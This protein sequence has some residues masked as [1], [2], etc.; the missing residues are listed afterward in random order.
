MICLVVVVFG[1]LVSRAGG[2]A[3]QRSLYD[4]SI[5]DN[6][7]LKVHTYATMVDPVGIAVGEYLDVKGLFVSSY[8][9][10]AISFISLQHYGHTKE[11]ETETISG[12]V[13]NIDS[14]GDIN[15]A[16]YA[17]PTRL[18]YDKECKMLFVACN[19]NKVIRVLNFKDNTVSTLQTDQNDIV[20]FE[21]SGLYQ[22]SLPGFDIQS[23]AGDSLYVTD[24]TQLHRVVSTAHESYCDSIASSA[25]LITY[26]SLA[27]YMQLHE[28]PSNSRI[29][30]VVPVE[31]KNMLY[32]AISDGMNVILT[33]P[34]G[35]VYSNQHADISRLVGNAGLSWSGLTNTQYPPVAT[36]GYAREGAVTL[37]FP[38]HLQLCG[39]GRTLWWTECFP[40]AGEFLL[41]S[42]AVR[43]IDIDSGMIEVM[44]ISVH[45]VRRCQT[46]IPLV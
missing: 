23:V 5:E 42:L 44:L 45:F 2:N 46:C 32:V 39:D 13:Y 26:H 14:D 8:Q 22:L 37:A 38:M 40:Y 10:N 33:V 43:R 25:A 34:T 27:Y 4:H 1:N 29:S 18:S 19:R 16:S 17:E 24:M 11:M 41:G 31:G 9:M 30:S 28:Y 21:S 6:L 36:N 12:G 7:A 15:T 3:G 35:A 20:T